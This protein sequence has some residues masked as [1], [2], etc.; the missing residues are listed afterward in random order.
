ML[1]V[2]CGQDTEPLIATDT[3]GALHGFLHHLCMTV[4]GWV[5]IMHNLCKA[6]WI[7]SALQMHHTNIS[8]YTWCVFG[9]KD[10]GVC[11]ALV[12]GEEIPG[13]W[14]LHKD[15]TFLW[16][17]FKVLQMLPSEP[18]AGHG[19]SC[20]VPSVWAR[21]WGRRG[22]RR[23]AVSPCQIN[24]LFQEVTTTFPTHWGWWVV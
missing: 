7:K 12:I 18:W 16:S 2:E 9:Q 23:P 5:N 20:E 24:Q 22:P 14:S 13:H 11:C 17:K 1:N 3:V 4:S 6:L 19:G 15:A 10:W 8:L 21:G